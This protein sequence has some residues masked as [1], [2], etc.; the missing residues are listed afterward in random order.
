MQ[1][2]RVF[3]TILCISSVVTVSN[4]IELP[5]QAQAE[6]LLEQAAF[7]VQSNQLLAAQTK[8]EQ[9]L[10]LALANKDLQGKKTL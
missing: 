7:L 6:Q 3:L 4:F 1:R 9:A 10:R 2:L 8:L 5:V